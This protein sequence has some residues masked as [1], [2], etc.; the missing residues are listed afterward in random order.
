MS[1]LKPK[2]S[3]VAG[4]N[5]NIWTDCHSAYAT[6]ELP[7]TLEYYFC[8]NFVKIT[9]LKTSEDIFQKIMPLAPNISL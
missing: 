2:I 6:T 5:Q 1:Y 7:I 8:F 3:V 4:D 9:E